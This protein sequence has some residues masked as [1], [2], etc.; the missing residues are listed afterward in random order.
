M[1]FIRN[2]N[3]TNTKN[4]VFALFLGL[5]ACG[6]LSDDDK[7]VDLS[8]EDKADLCSEAKT[9]TKDCGMGLSIDGSPAQC[10]ASLK[11]VPTSCEATVGDVRSCN[12]LEDP[13]QAA[14]NAGCL[15][16][17]ACASNSGG[18]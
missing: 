12:E 11:N 10:E 8:D 18:N 3:I 9:F 16:M 13:C 6:G 15:K 14:T 5:A 7:L 2:T 1:K 17:A 4:W